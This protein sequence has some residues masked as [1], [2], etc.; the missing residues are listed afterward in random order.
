MGKKNKTKEKKPQKD[1]LTP[2][3]DKSWQKSS[4]K[5]KV[6]VTAEDMFE[7]PPIPGSSGVEC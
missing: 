3:G 5:K 6:K 4:D 7:C 2:I 1:I